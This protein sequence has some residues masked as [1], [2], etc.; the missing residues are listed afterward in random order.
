MSNRN[1]LLKE[2]GILGSDEAAIQEALVALKIEIADLEDQIRDKRRELDSLTHTNTINTINKMEPTTTT[3][4]ETLGTLFKGFETTRT[5]SYI[6]QL[7]NRVIRGQRRYGFYEGEE[8]GVLIMRQN[9]EK[10]YEEIAD[11]LNEAGIKTRNG[12][13]WTADRVYTVMQS[14][15]AKEAL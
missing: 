14:T 2:M 15:F 10:S 9:L 1:K 5:R 12:R 7:R 6:K 13:S 4:S 11:L 8:K 3:R